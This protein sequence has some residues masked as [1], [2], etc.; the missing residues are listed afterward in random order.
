MHVVS[1]YV[2]EPLLP[3]RGGTSC[4]AHGCGSGEEPALNLSDEQ[5]A[6]IEAAKRAAAERVSGVV[7]SKK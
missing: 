7:N 4:S 3:K 5:L 2:E 6:R 1:P